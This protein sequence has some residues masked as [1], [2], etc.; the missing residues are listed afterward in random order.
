MKGYLMSVP[1]MV[2]PFAL[3]NWNVDRYELCSR[4]V[5]QDW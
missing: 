1:Y 2:V 5:E 4:S 3:E